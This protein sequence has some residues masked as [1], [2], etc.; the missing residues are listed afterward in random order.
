MTFTLAC[1]YDPDDVKLLSEV[2]GTKIYQGF[3]VWCMTS[4]GHIRA[5][6]NVF[7]GVSRTRLPK[8][9]NGASRSAVLLGTLLA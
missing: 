8:S 6:A 7:D 4:I 2:A 1:P 9:G 3:F 5:A